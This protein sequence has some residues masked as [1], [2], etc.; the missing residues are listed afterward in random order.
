MPYARHVHG[1]AMFVAVINAQ[2]V[3][4]RSSWL[5]HRLDSGV[6]GQFNAIGEGE[7]R[8]GSH[9]RTV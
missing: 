6:I 8:I 9:D 7:E 2:L 3:F 5:D 1:E 4:D